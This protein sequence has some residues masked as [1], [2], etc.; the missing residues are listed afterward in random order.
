MRLAMMLPRPTTPD[1][2]GWPDA[3][4]AFGWATVGGARALGLAED[5][6]RIA[7]GCRADLAVL[8]MHGVAEAPLALNLTALVQHATPACVRATMV[9]GRWAYRDGHILAFDEPAVLRRFAALQARLIE[10]TRAEVATAAEATPYFAGL[11]G[12]C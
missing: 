9:G 7:E 2:S 8:D 12:R 3:R 4:E 11:P 5:L 6:G 10:S 1:P